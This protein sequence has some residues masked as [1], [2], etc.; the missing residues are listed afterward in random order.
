MTET[1]YYI[2]WVGGTIILT[3]VLMKV[4]AVITKRSFA[5]A[6][7]K[8]NMD[9]TNYSFLKN[10][11]NFIVILMAVILLFNKIPALKSIGNTVLAGA[12]I[13][14]AA[15]GFASQQAF[16]NIISG[17][18]MIIFKPFRVGDFIQAETNTGWVEEITLRH[19]I[20]R[21]PENRRIIVPN[22]II[23]SETIVNSSY[24]DE[25]I[26]VFIEVGISYR[27]D[28]DKA[29]QILREEAEKHPSMIDKR[30]KQ[31][32][33][34]GD[35]PIWI[36]V[37]QLAESSV[38]IRAAV[39]GKDQPASFGMKCDILKSTKERF[40]KEGIEIPFPYHNVI[41]KQQ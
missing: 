1:L 19:T 21:S 11:I 8:L 23:S 25:D 20:I 7:V 5:R 4:V 27:S 40:D 15:I 36:K 10:A 26:K 13:L 24:N 2:L 3:I 29:M 9:P 30:T 12:G 31:E 33:K 41:I 38:V 34:N 37:V 28:I 14:A 32:K 16:S 18:F 6:A 17:V 35:S 22:A 39:W